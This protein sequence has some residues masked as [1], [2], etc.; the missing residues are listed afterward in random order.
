[1]HRVCSS[2]DKNLDTLKNTGA[3]G[4]MPEHGTFERVVEGSF[5]VFVG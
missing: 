5:L 3:M 2:E 1:M 4:G